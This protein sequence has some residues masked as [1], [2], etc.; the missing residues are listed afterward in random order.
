MRR[1]RNTFLLL[2]AILSVLWS[3]ADPI[4][5]MPYEFYAYRDS[6][7][8]LTGVLAI[9]AMSMAMVLAVRW[10]ALETAMGGLDKAYRLHKWMGIAG[11]V[12]SILHFLLANVPKILASAG[13]IPEPEAA[14]SLESASAMYRF[15]ASQYP[16][17]EEFGDWGFKIALVLIVIALVK[18]FP[19]RFFL[20]SHRLL[21]AVY[22]CLALHS[23]ILM[24]F[25]Y[26]DSAVAPVVTLL[27]A[28]G[29]VAAV[30]S[31]L[32]RVGYRRRAIGEIERLQY[33][34]D[35]SVLKIGVRLR[36]HWDGHE[37]GQFAFVTFDRHEGAHPFTI[38]SP[39]RD[40]GRVAFFVKGLGDYT[41][42]LPGTLRVG[43]LATVEGPYGRFG[44][45]S[46]KPRQ[47]WVAGG[48]G[49]APF[50]ARLKALIRS[51]GEQPIDLF[52]SAS[53]PED[54]EFLHRLRA[55]AAEARVELHVTVPSQDGRLD[56]E[57]I[58]QEVPEW[59]DADFWFCGPTS[60]GETLQR[61]LTALGLA[62][63]SFHRE[64]F[65]M[66]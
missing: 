22:L 60:F 50:V 64:L 5:G 14:P 21:S 32:G 39:W 31:L 30:Q 55:A 56:V 15:F 49:I 44:F 19:Y 36:G 1:I 11:L 13:Y 37:E 17:A 45:E 66:R 52:Y 43:D 27:A 58:C 6:M 24:R 62:P 4:F 10:S 20:R 28:A 26:W 63:S 2:F 9:G 29:S 33:H 57:R 40:D 48:I 61:G 7:L 65:D 34:E 41:K 8:N 53:E 51:P 38:A 23:I 16:L 47:I 46:D 12:F 35:N 3:L 25:S 18:K 59:R 42:T 54:P